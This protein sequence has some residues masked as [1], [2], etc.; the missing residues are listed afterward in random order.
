[1]PSKTYELKAGSIIPAS[2]ANTGQSNT[3]ELKAGSIIPASSANTGKQI[4][5]IGTK[6]ELINSEMG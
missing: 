3:Y 1:M 4:P 5:V 2:P 6:R